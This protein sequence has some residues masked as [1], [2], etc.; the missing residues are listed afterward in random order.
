MDADAAGGGQAADRAAADRWPIRRT[1][2]S[3]DLIL[4]Y[5]VGNTHPRVFGW[6]HGCGMASGLLP[7]L[8]AAAMNANLGGRDMAPFM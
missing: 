4:P 3:A 2:V 6:V 8:M 1:Q 5:G 7:E